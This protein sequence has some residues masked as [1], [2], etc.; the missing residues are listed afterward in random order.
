MLCLLVFKLD[1]VQSDWLE[2][3]ECVCLLVF[4]DVLYNSCFGAYVFLY[5]FSEKR[6]SACKD[7]HPVWD[8]QVKLVSSQFATTM[9][10][11]RFHLPLDL[12]RWDCNIVEGVSEVFGEKV[13]GFGIEV[14]VE[15]E[16]H[17]VIKIEIKVFESKSSNLIL[18]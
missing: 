16:R 14:V 17:I 10:Y 3:F 18:I 9:V 6:T 15:C 1:M 7:S 12:L 2:C 5:L 13:A 4:R 8:L 11:L